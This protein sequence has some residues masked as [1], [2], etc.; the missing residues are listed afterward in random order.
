MSMSG[1]LEW[2][3]ETMVKNSDEIKGR[4]KEAAGAITGN[5]KL[6][7]EGRADRVAGGAKSKVKRAAG[8][9]E[10]LIDKA[11]DTHRKK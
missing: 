5:K 6:K 3:G 4:A 1:Y 7:A 11:R 8:K 2:K 10:E 9:M